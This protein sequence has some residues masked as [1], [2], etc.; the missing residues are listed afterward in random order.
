MASSDTGSYSV[1]VD[2]ARKAIIVTLQGTPTIE[3]ISAVIDEIYDILDDDTVTPDNPMHIVTDCSQIEGI[4]FKLKDIR[5]NS[6]L[7]QADNVYWSIVIA[8]PTL[9]GNIVKLFTTIITSVTETR[10]RT[11]STLDEAFA[12]LDSGS[13]PYR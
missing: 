13:N 3:Q 4:P 11:F 5:S 10:F 2:Q 8:P 7:T 9:I 1:E 6:R 12:F